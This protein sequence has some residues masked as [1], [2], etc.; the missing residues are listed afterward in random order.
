MKPQ[1]LE[2]DQLTSDFARVILGRGTAL[3]VI[4][5]P[6][7]SA[8]SQLGELIRLPWSMVVVESTS[9]AL[10]QSVA[11]TDDVT[12]IFARHRGFVYLVASDPEKITLPKRCLPVYFINGRDDAKEPSERPGN[13]GFQAQRRRLNSLARLIE[14]QPD[15]LVVICDDDS[16]SFN[17]VIQLIGSSFHPLL[18]LI[19]AKAIVLEKAKASYADVPVHRTATFISSELRDVLSTFL[20]AAKSL[21]APFETKIRYRVDAK[22]HV[23]LNISE[24]DLIEDPVLGRYETVKIQDQLPAGENDLRR[25]DL[26]Q[27]FDK[28]HANW[29][30]Y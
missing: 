11:K 25:E 15:R 19:S 22:H 24:C 20:T 17:D 12:D 4:T 10:A 28:A 6:D 27:F 23:E 1:I 9:S 16:F 21:Y 30:P 26:E 5:S 8:V 18:T 14:A 29:R 2:R 7:A 3:W 13:V